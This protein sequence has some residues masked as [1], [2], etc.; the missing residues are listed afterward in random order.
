VI[1]HTGVLAG[2]CASAVIMFFMAV[3][4]LVAWKVAW[5]WDPEATS[6]GQLYL[7]RQV[8][9]VGTLMR[10][11]L[12]ISIFSLALFIYTVDEFSHLLTGAMCA[13]GSLNANPI[14]WW[15]LAVKL[16]LIFLGGGWL[17]V[18]HLDRS[19]PD[20]ALT[21]LKF[22]LL[23]LLAPLVALDGVLQFL[24]FSGLKI[25][26]ITSCCG[27]L[28]SASGDTLISSISAMKPVKAVIMF[29]TFL[30]LTI[31]VELAALLRKSLCLTRLVALFSI[32]MFFVGAIAVVSFASSYY[33]KTPTHHCPFDLLQ[34]ENYYVG[35]PLWGSWLAATFFGLAGWSVNKIS[36]GKIP[37]EIINKNLQTWL[38]ISLTM[39]ALFAFLIS[40]PLLFSDFKL[41]SY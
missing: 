14:G 36:T 31:F 34:R 10:W 23:W 21:P 6:A 30:S 28:F 1:L 41:L 22:K 19:T 32:I 33:Y 7:E 17:L 24:Y 38:I 39:W 20:F 37:E 16:L 13:T 35:Y 29:Y 25:D 12:F 4:L 26:V 11:A 18:N 8:E 40:Y 15:A 2:L 3:G 27:S 9:L 5:R